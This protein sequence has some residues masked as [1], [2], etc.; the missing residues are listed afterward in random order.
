[1]G[2]IAGKEMRKTT[3]MSKRHREEMRDQINPKTNIPKGQEAKQQ[4]K[5]SPRFVGAEHWGAVRQQH[6]R[7]FNAPTA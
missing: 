4:L 7:R 3:N 6:P 1:M 5:A 2:V